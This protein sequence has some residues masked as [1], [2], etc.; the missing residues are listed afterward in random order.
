MRN[1][2]SSSSIMKYPHQV[3]HDKVEALA[4]RIYLQEKRPS[5]PARDPWQRAEDAF[6][7]LEESCAPRPE[8]EP[9]SVYFEGAT[10]LCPE[11]PA[12]FG[13]AVIHRKNTDGDAMFYPAS[14]QEMRAPLELPATLHS[15]ET[16]EIFHLTHLQ[17][18]EEGEACF[19]ISFRNESLTPIDPNYGWKDES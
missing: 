14:L 7:N 13:L 12:I 10:L 3:A 11:H 4:Y 1:N 19:D 5:N 8:E 16:G 2:A 9:P 15:D 18:R 17:P 6:R